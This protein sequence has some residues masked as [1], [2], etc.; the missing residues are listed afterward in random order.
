MTRADYARQI[1]D[2]RRALNA[3]YVDAIRLAYKA[4]RYLYPHDI[5]ALD[6]LASQAKSYISY[7][8]RRTRHAG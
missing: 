2:A 1:E 3:S 6:M 8:R 7:R 4:S 5:A